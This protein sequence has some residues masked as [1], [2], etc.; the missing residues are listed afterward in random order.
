MSVLPDTARP[1]PV[2][3]VPAMPL[4]AMPLAAMSLAAM[5]L[6]VAPLAVLSLPADHCSCDVTSPG[7]GVVLLRI[8][9]EVDLYSV[10]LVE[11]AVRTVLRGAPAHVVVDLAAMSFC[12]LH[13]LALLVSAAAD[14]AARGVGFSV[15]GASAQA[16]RVWSALWAP[17]EQFAHHPD[18]VAGVRAA[19][20]AGPG[21]TAGKPSA[22]TDYPG[23]RVDRGQ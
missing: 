15:C 7:A 11:D 2:L 21:I 9:G 14:A 18:A 12:G 8:S 13:G 10:G 16:V 5:S 17:A 6:A 23:G 19:C 4:A 1:V 20:A 3:S 22:A